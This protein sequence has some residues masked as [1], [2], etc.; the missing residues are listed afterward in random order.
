MRGH[1]PALW[2]LLWEIM[3]AYPEPL[4]NQVF[5]ASFTFLSLPYS[6]ADKRS[7]DLSLTNWLLNIGIWVCYSIYIY[8]YKYVHKYVYIII[9]TYKN[10]QIYKQTCVYIFIYVL[11]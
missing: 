2:G 8:T 1:K 10:I 5:S 7:L 11:L 6:A 3:Q 9:Y 4:N